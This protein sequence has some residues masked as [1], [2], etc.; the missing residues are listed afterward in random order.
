MDRRSLGR[1]GPLVSPI[2]FGAFKIGRNQKIKY[3]SPY[4]LPDENQVGRLLN[5]LLD[6]GINYFDTAPAY[7]CSEERIG[8][9][10]GHRRQ[11]FVLSTKV[12]ET[13]EQ[14]QSSYDFSGAAVEASI[15]QSL[16]RLNTDFL[17]LVFIHSNG[18]D[19]AIIEESDAIAA[20]S[21]LRERGLI[22]MIGMSATSEQ[23]IEAAIP[24][25]DAVMVTYHINDVSQGPAIATAADAGLGVVVKKGLGSGRLPAG[26]AIP[27]VLANQHI[28]TLVIGS[29]SLPHMEQNLKIALGA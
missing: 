19:V 4:D 18:N 15:R 10:I 25:A 29:L 16:V 28:A 21:K 23:G 6:A 9:A 7:G 24:W 2:G 27:F 8:R 12:G 5:G 3:D 13:F 1:N 11:E 26:E 22:R 17:D 20:L 14:G